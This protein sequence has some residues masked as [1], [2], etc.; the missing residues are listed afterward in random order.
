MKFFRHYIPSIKDN[1]QQP[2]Q[3]TKPCL[4]EFCFGISL[5]GS[6]TTSGPIF[7]EKLHLVLNETKTYIHDG[8]YDFVRDSTQVEKMPLSRNIHQNQATQYAIDEICQRFSPIIPK[9]FVMKVENAEFSA[10]KAN[11]PDD[12]SA[13]L[14]SFT[15][16]FDSFASLCHFS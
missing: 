16:N 7:I 12:F 9:Q 4:A 6:M 3:K 8:L 2:Q 13:K 5:D 1:Q 14:K 15:V 11:S 10:I